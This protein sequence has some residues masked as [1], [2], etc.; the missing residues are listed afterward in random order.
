V[1]KL[2]SKRVD[3][4]FDRKDSIP[5]NHFNLPTRFINQLISAYKYYY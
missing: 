2:T 4:L 3:K 5:F 1:D